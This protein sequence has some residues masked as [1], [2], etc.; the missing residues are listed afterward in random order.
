MAYMRYW[1]FVILSVGWAGCS[2]K[3]PEPAPP[4]PDQ[5]W[6]HVDPI[7]SYTSIKVDAFD[8][9][10]RSDEATRFFNEKYPIR[11][12]WELFEKDPRIIRDPE[13]KRE[14]PA[15]RLAEFCE[16]HIK[17]DT[18]QAL[19]HNPMKKGN[20][21][22]RTGRFVIP[23]TPDIDALF[24]LPPAVA[25]FTFRYKNVGQGSSCSWIREDIQGNDDVTQAFGKPDARNPLQAGGLIQ[26][27]FA[28]DNVVVFCSGDKVYDIHILKSEPDWAREYR[29]Q[30]GPPLKA[31][32][33]PKPQEP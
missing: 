19:P 13:M 25:R 28:K 2:R 4:S 9:L 31:D 17:V 6:Y 14:I 16:T 32:E 21:R 24:D 8:K 27:Y 3:P 26:Y 23:R 1:L 18:I 11:M 12:G 22:E 20:P 15:A 30:F 29:G 33:L 7:P 10:I 5:K